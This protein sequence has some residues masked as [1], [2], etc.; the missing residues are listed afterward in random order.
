VSEP[1]HQIGITELYNEIR[2]LSERFTEYMSR[3]SVESTSMN[4]KVSELEKDL[5]EV[6][7]D[8]KAEHVRRSNTAWQMKLAVASSLIFP[9]IVGVVVALIVSKG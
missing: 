6:K 1:V 2:A 3:H 8:L 9:I 4:H 5:A 7:A